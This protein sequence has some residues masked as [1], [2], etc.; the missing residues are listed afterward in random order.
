VKIKSAALPLLAS[1]LIVTP[2]GAAGGITGTTAAPAGV[3][4]ATGVPDNSAASGTPGVNTNAPIPGT[5][6]PGIIGTTGLTI[7]TTS[8]ALPGG[9]P[10]GAAPGTTNV[11]AIA[12]TPTG[13]NAPAVPLNMNR[14]QFNDFVVSRWDMN[15]TTTITPQ[16]WDT[17]SPA[18]FGTGNAPPFSAIDTNNDGI[19]EPAEL[20]SYLDKNP[21]LFDKF[22]TNHNGTIDGAEGSQIPAQ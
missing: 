7:G 18:W 4:P 8:P 22:D 17:I 6:L 15:G 10:P 21:A 12:V 19:L 2:A 1:F 14:Q 13:G 11:P 5:S 16:N 20:Q 3:N 9:G